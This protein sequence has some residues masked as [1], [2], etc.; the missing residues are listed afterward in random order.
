MGEFD[1]VKHEWFQDM[2]G[3]H[4]TLT[5]PQAAQN[6]KSFPTHPFSPGNTSVAKHCEILDQQRAITVSNLPCNTHNK[7][8][9]NLASRT[10][11]S[12]LERRKEIGFLGG[13]S[14]DGPGCAQAHRAFRCHT[15]HGYDLLM[16]R[17]A[18]TN[19]RGWNE[20]RA[21]GGKRL[22][23][24]CS[25]AAKGVTNDRDAVQSISALVRE[26]DLPVSPDIF[27][28]TF[29]NVLQKPAALNRRES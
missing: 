20:E 26:R 7:S 18:E 10:C 3:P 24:L 9:S 6:G 15:Q 22:A 25:R 8:I 19:S 16:D 23:Y 14:A 5:W 21:L 13:K 11:D 28:G 4:E 27:L 1:F 17:T 2:F 12:D 29:L